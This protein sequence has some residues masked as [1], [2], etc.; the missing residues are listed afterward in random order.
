MVHRSDIEAKA[1]QI[2]DA[3]NETRDT[4]KTSATW[5]IAGVILL[6]VVV[7]LLGRRQGKQ[8]GAVVEV[9]RV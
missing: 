4:A 5:A 8:G 7:F 1:R 3:L 9:Y 6:A 2:E